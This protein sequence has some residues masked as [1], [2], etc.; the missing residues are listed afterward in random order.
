MNFPSSC[1]FITFKLPLYYNMYLEHKI[2]LCLTYY[3]LLNLFEVILADSVLLMCPTQ[4]MVN[5]EEL[6][7]L[8]V[9]MGKVCVT[10][11]DCNFFLNFWG[12]RIIDNWHRAA[13][14]LSPAL[15][16]VEKSEAWETK[17]QKW[18][19]YSFYKFNHIYHCITTMIICSFYPK[20]ILLYYSTKYL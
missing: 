18:Y 4:C 20:S 3:L 14:N 5:T 6:P 13:K 8:S 19:T 2:P 11:R 1:I 15:N 7:T 9:P 12:R 16:V 17:W 10:A